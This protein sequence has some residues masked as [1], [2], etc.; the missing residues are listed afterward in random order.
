MPF[1]ADEG[2]K[3]MLRACFDR[4]VP[5]AKHSPVAFPLP[6]IASPTD[7]IAALCTIVQGVS[8]GEITAIEA[9]EM[10]MVVRSGSQIASESNLEQRI[11]KIEETDA[12]NAT[13]PTSAVDACAMRDVCRYA[14][15]CARMTMDASGISARRLR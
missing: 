13:G 15:V 7:A 8:E 9:A 1:E 12:A 5:R 2:D 6:P 14:K 3:T 11:R 10:A 4:L